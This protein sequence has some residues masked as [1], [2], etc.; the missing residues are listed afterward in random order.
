MSDVAERDHMAPVDAIGASGELTVQKRQWGSRAQLAVWPA[1]IALMVIGGFVSPAFWTQRNFINVLQ[2]ASVLAVLTLA[3]LLVVLVRKFD[4]S[5]ESTV[6]FAPMLAAHIILPAPIGFGGS[7]P[8]WTGFIIALGIGALVGVCNAVLVVKLQ[9]NAFIAT[10]GMLILLRGAT[11][12]ISNGET[13]VS[14]PVGMV[15]PGAAMIGSVPVSVI[16]GALLYLGAW[17]FLRYHQVGRNLYAIGGNPVASRAAGIRVERTVFGV[18]VVAGLLA[19]FAGL[20]LSGRIDSIVAS[21]GSGTVFDVFAA[22]AIG[23]VSLNGGKGT[24]GGA[25]SG[26][27]FLALLANILI[28]AG[29]SSFWVDM[30]RGAI[31]I[32]ALVLSRFT[33]GPAND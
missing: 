9:I 29:L 23:G 3:M 11:L 8:G 4:L 32:F 5:I 31:I 6:A 10:L 15:W 25:L 28:L 33:G 27:L 13:V 20:M 2:Q 7:L 19:A 1:I 12:G 30:A 26:V 24:V 14:P 21:Q 22:L 16:L 18:F 17:F